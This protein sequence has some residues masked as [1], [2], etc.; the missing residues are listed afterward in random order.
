LRTL[1][2]RKNPGLREV[3][4]SSAGHQVRLLRCAAV[5]MRTVRCTEQPT[6][7]F[8]HPP[9][10]GLK[11]RGIS[12]FLP[13]EGWSRLGGAGVDQSPRHATLWSTSFFRRLGKSAYRSARSTALRTLPAR[14]IPD[15]VKSGILLR[16][17]RCGYCA[18]PPGWKRGSFQA[19]GARVPRSTS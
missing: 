15:F 19:N 13:L 10:R 6:P 7:R 4:D 11:T 17:I 16:A 3:R 1:P 5:T 8:A 9:R 18:A 12:G 14:N 2:A